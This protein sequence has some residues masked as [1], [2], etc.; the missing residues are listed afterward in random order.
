[1][2]LHYFRSNPVIAICNSI[3]MRNDSIVNNFLLVTR[4]LFIY[5]LFKKYGN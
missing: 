2:K 1:M 4:I 5:N 3:T